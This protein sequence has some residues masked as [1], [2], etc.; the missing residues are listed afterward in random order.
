[1]E[2]V[3][4]HGDSRWVFRGHGDPSFTLTPGVGRSAS[5]RLADERTILEIFDRRV[6]EFRDAHYMTV[7]DKLALAQHHGLPTRLLDWTSN[8]LVAA[9]FAVTAEAANAQGKL[10]NG[11]ARVTGKALSVRPEKRTIDAQIIAWPVTSRSVIDTGLQE[12]PFALTDIGFL[13][14]RSLTTRIV[15]QGG[16]FSVHPRPNDPWLEPL[17]DPDDIFVIPGN[18]RTYFQRKLFYLG[19][20]PQRIMGGID[21]LCARV[22]WQYHS[23]IGF[24]AVR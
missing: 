8:P 15:T 7:W 4:R 24:G 18:L 1:M 21:G 22:A 23:H 11:T 9:F 12:D 3:D 16:L 14:P 10:L 5:Y 19:I 2:W 17:Q 20:D 13:L 6:P